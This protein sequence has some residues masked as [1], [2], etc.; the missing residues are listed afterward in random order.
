MEGI[1]I[2]TVFFG[3][4]IA[5][6]WLTGRVKQYR[7]EKQVELQQ[8]LL[9]KFES[10]GELVEF[11]DTETGRNFMRQFESNPRRIILGFLSAGIVLTFLGLGFHG[12]AMSNGDFIIPGV[13]TLVVGI[14]FIVAAA[15]SRRMSRQWQ[16]DSQDGS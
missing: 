11:L 5:I 3:N 16:Q 4:V 1:I 2:P 13:L 10:A 15:I 14:G 9:A 8:Q 7:I 12:L 6:V